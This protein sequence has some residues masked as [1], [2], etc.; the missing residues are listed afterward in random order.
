MTPFHENEIT[1]FVNNL[2]LVQPANAFLRTREPVQPEL[3]KETGEQT[4][5][6]D[7]SIISFVSDVSAQNR[8]DI[9][10]STLLAQLAANKTHSLESDMQQWY[11]AFISVL[12]KVGWVVEAGEVNKFESKDSVFEV[13]NVIID[14]LTAAFG[15]SYITI[16]KKVLESFKA[17][18]E[19]NKIKVFEKNTHTLSK[20]C[21]QIG[22]ASEKNGAVSMQLGT[23][24]L[25]STNEIKKILFVKIAKDKT[26]LAYSSRQATFNQEVYAA[27]RQAI[28]TKLSSDIT[29]YV[30]ELEI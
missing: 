14:I 17:M 27:A 16:I 20:G 25:T 21:F 9:L 8:N 23:F 19:N 24:L 5:L 28:L 15:S 30:A 26:S 6:S 7:K 10:N 3:V 4:F 11:Q 2:E 13:E 18:S 22:L 29:D 12:N 1:D